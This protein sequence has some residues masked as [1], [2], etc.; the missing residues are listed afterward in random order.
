MK[1]RFKK[2]SKGIQKGLKT[3][4]KIEKRCSYEAQNPPRIR[5]K[6][7]VKQ[8]ELNFSIFRTAKDRYQELE[9]TLE[10]AIKDRKNGA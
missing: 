2:A 8:V 10:Q 9:R 4:I 6:L 5:L 7:S 1:K 3:D